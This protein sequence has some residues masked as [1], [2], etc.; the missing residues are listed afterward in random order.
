MKLKRFKAALALLVIVSM[1]ISFPGLSSITFA[2]NVVE[3]IP[4]T[5]EVGSGTISGTVTDIA[6]GDPIENV[7]ILMKKDGLP[8]YFGTKSNSLGEYSDIVP[9][10]NYTVYAEGAEVGYANDFKEDITVAVDQTTTVDFQLDKVP[11][12]I[13][14]GKVTDFTTASADAQLYKPI[15]GGKIQ[16]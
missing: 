14:R 15:P 9:A 6:T 1:I 7:Q 8:Y 4:Q 16:A 11:S 3:Y 2:S 13:I 10:G 12:G 5:E